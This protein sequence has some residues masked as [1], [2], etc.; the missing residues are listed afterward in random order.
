MNIHFYF[1]LQFNVKFFG[2]IVTLFWL[3]VFAFGNHTTRIEFSGTGIDQNNL[4]FVVSNDN[5]LLFIQLL[6][7]FCCQVLNKDKVQ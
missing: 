1:V 4:T 5:F 7:Y 6:H 3:R 2:E